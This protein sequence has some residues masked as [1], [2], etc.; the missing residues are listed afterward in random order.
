[1][2]E[3]KARLRCQKLREPKLENLKSNIKLIPMEINI[4]WSI[5]AKVTAM[6]Y[7]DRF[8]GCWYWTAC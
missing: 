2:K 6:A 3:E 1:M 5:K 4:S 7:F 8:S